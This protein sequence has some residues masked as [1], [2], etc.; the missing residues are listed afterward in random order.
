MLLDVSEGIEVF[1]AFL[2]ADEVKKGGRVIEI[3]A[4]AA[5]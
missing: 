4:F 5:H 1:G 3:N 2:F